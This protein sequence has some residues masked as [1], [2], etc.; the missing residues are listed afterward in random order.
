MNS[1]SGTFLLHFSAS[2][3]Y[4]VLEAQPTLQHETAIGHQR[5]GKPS[6]CNNFHAQELYVVVE[7][8]LS[9]G[10]PWPSEAQRQKADVNK[11]TIGHFP[12]AVFME[13]R[14]ARIDRIVALKFGN[15]MYIG[16]YR[17]DART[18]N[19]RPK[20]RCLHGGT[21]IATFS[22]LISV[23]AMACTC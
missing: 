13:A 21:A 16:M 7:G 9:K 6:F 19:P 22:P 23:K 18:F 2:W 12:C 14:K 17:L 3:A 8:A 4:G 15:R 10:Q 1:L 20:T 11:T 5:N